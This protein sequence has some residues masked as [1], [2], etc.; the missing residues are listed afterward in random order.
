M[1]SKPLSGR[2]DAVQH[3]QL[4]RRVKQASSMAGRTQHT[5]PQQQR[6]LDVLRERGEEGELGEGGAGGSTQP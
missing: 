5:R 3:K 4:S 6:S 2:T 1:L